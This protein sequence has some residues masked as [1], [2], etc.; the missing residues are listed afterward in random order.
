MAT[1]VWEYEVPTNPPGSVDVV[2]VNAAAP[3]TVWVNA[4]GIVSPVVSVIASV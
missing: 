3:L 1:K 2:M 4:R